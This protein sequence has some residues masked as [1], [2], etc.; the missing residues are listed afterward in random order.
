MKRFTYLLSI[1]VAAFAIAAVGMIGCE[2]PAGAT[3]QAGIDGVDGIDGIDANETCKVCHDY[4]TELLAKQLQ[5]A[6][7]AHMTGG[8]YRYADRT[9]CS[10]CHTH[11][12]FMEVMG[13]A[14]YE[15]STEFDEGT[16][17]NCRTCH[18]IH[19]TY[20]Q[21]DFAIRVTEPVTFWFNS[22]EADLGKSNQC[23]ACHQPR[24]G[25]LDDLPV[26]GGADLVIDDDDWGYPHQSQSS[27]V[28][29]TGGYETV[30]SASYPTA[31]SST[32]ASTGCV[33]CHMVEP[34][35][36]NTAG[37][38]TMLMTYHSHSGSEREFTNSCENCHGEDTDFDYAN[39]QTDVTT[40]LD[41]LE[42]LLTAKN[43]MVDGDLNASTVAPLTLTADEAGAYLNLQMVE[44]EKSTGVHNP[45]YIKAILKNSIEAMK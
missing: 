31:G 13:T 23:I 34:G 11:E 40:M 18:L 36:G 20:T 41:S 28:F 3:G 24:M 8:H 12:G 43:I 44:R 37:G 19:E 38:H 22:V 5:T 4:G 30:G 6:A 9:D 35:R 26:V 7:S 29:G 42:V 39:I 10:V 45:R 16:A 14:N 25:D 2:G 33:G 21:S 15:A 32:H 27:M 17:P 1:T